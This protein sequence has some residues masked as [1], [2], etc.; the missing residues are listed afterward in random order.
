MIVI[1]NNI[2]HG[3]SIDLSTVIELNSTRMVIQGLSTNM[4]SWKGNVGYI[5][6]ALDCDTLWRAFRNSFSFEKV[7]LSMQKYDESEKH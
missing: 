4:I 6:I 5:R 3:G 1:G 2:S 7:F